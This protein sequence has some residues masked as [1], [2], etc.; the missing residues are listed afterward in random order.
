MKS[1]KL[2]IG[3]FVASLLVYVSSLYFSS[4]QLLMEGR[5][6]ARI[7]GYS[8]T[9]G[10]WRERLE[11]NLKRE[12]IES[13]ISVEG[14]GLEGV[15]LFAINGE[16]TRS[17]EGVFSMS[18]STNPIQTSKVVDGYEAVSYTSLFLS[19]HST[20]AL[21]YQDKDIMMVEGPRNAVM[22]IRSQGTVFK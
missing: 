7:F 6:I 19:G 20:N 10:F 16:V 21:V 18:Y 11:L 12:N 8:E 22:L 9:N 15:A 3:I 5:Y 1:L 2:W 17:D 4:Q 13:T 14:D